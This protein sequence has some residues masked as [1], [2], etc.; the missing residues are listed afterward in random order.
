MSWSP[1]VRQLIEQGRADAPEVPSGYY[2]L[3]TMR[4]SDEQMQ[5]WV[6]AYEEGRVS[7]LE[8]Y[9]VA[10]PWHVVGTIE[11]KIRYLRG[12]LPTGTEEVR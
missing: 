2:V 7:A 8:V 10:R 1:Y 6:D 5:F 3:W 9:Q 4:K 12:E 11:E